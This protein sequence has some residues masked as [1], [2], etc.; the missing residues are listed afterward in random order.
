MRKKILAVLALFAA[1]TVSIFGIS[2]CTDGTSSGSSPGSIGGSIGS[3]SS[4]GDETPTPSIALNKETV[5][6]PV[7]T[8]E[9]L[10]ATLSN[11]DEI[12]D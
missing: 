7:Y 8:S 3:E 9:T 4:P 2:A 6:L 5:S 1:F 11:S 10:T 12:I